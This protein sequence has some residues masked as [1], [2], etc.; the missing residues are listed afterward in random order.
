MHGGETMAIVGE[1]GSGKSTIAL[2]MMG[3]LPKNASVRGSI[4]VGETEIVG[5]D[6]R[7]APLG[8]RPHRVDDLPGADDRPEPR[9]H[10]RVPD[11]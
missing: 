10:R 3:L 6:A 11:R 8:A 9:V 1:S 7:V 5:L 4:R 2:A